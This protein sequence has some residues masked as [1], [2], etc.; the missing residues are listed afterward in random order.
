MSIFKSKPSP[1]ISVA[2]IMAAGNG[3][4]LRQN[5]DPSDPAQAVP[6]QYLKLN[7]RPILAYSLAAFLHHP[8]ITAIQVVIRPEDQELYLACLKEFSQ[9]PEFAKLMPPVW[10]GAERQISVVN[11]L[12][13]LNELDPYRVFIHDAARPGIDAALITRLLAAA[14]GE[15]G[16]IP[17]LPVA[18]SLKR[19]DQAGYCHETVTR[20]GLWLAQTPQ[21]FNY[22]AILTAHRKFP[23]MIAS[24]DGKLAEAAGL[25]IKLVEGAR[26]LLK[27][28][29]PQDLQDMAAYF[30]QS[31]SGH[32]YATRIGQGFDVHQLARAADGRKLMLCGVHIPSDLALVGH[33]DADVGLHAATDAILGAL[34][35][36]DIGGHFLPSDPRWKNADSSQF[37]RH[38]AQLVSEQ[39]GRIVNLD[40]T[41][42]CEAPHIAPHRA[43]MITRMAE[44]LAIDPARISVKATTTEKLGFTGRG[45]GIAAMAVTS[46][47]LP[48]VGR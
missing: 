17:A 24:D 18:D 8:H 36:G 31:H 12:A 40:V 22:Q 10:G 30:A 2:L 7:H 14:M 47:Q 43:A 21:V 5:L 42:I 25:R 38:A 19:Q 41:L 32:A 11:G 4:R 29:H 15:D 44:I 23:A 26:R 39:G 45:E 37:L 6:K 3:T 28:T 46:I 33:S 1:Q 16:V 13:A 48:E 27:I 34:A 9:L 35:A 20:D